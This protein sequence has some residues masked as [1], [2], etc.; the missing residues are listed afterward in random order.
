M[1]ILSSLLLLALP[2]SLH[3]QQPQGAGGGND[4]FW[5]VTVNTMPTALRQRINDAAYDMQRQGGG[6]KSFVGGLLKTLGFSTVSSLID[7]MTT[8]TVNLVKYR[9][10]QKNKWMQMIRN[11]S[12]YTDS[13]TAVKGL[14]DFYYAPSTVGA[15]DPS[16]INFDG[17]SIRGMREGREMLYL[18]CHIDT[19]QLDHLFRH[20]K[21]C[22]VVDTLAFHP[23][24]CHLPNLQANGI[25]TARQ[26]HPAGPQA[27]SRPTRSSSDAQTS[28][29]KQSRKEKKRKK[30]EERDNSYRFSERQNLNV[31][32]DIT[33]ES[34]WVNEAVMVQQNVQLGR[35]RLNISV[36]DGQVLYTY[37]RRRQEEN[38]RSGQSADTAFV[39]IEGDCFVVPRSFMPMTNGQRQ[40]GTG[41]YN[42][43]V[44]FRESCQFAPDATYNEKL[45]HWHRD[46]K[47]LRR[48]QRKGNETAE[49]LRSIWQQNGNTFTK[50]L[51]K[52]T[53]TQSAQA[54]HLTQKQSGLSGTMPS[55]GGQMPSGA[56]AGGASA[57]GSAMPAGAPGKP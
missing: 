50:T 54:A 4:T 39:N 47:Q 32:M 48:L 29:P 25:R 9:K 10:Q 1:R 42:M 20:S 46:Y 31:G 14:K 37:S 26:D 18:S 8:E 52:Q 30:R 23:L 5:Q 33:L 51:I 12:A 38:R 28:A 17:I 11:E 36:P 41:E 19:T 34:S 43:K 27:D 24:S 55:G 40:W 45:R 53:L 49:Y 21:F 13:I 22:L 2:L 3:A 7:V 6:D 35:F 57:G 44:R 56:A 15:L 16:N